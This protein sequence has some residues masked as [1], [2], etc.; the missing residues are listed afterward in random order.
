M[1]VL[2][3]RFQSEAGRSNLIPALS[4]TF[5]GMILASAI[6]SLYIFRESGDKPVIRL[7]LLSMEE[8]PAHFWLRTRGGVGI[9]HFICT[10]WQVEDEIYPFSVQ[11]L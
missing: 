9:S 4:C 3:V 7:G 11:E 8:Q 6:E 5:L 1:F 2:L 10:R